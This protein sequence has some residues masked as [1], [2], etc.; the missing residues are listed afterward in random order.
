M[1]LTHASLESIPTSF[2]TVSV[3][4]KDDHTLPRKL[5]TIAAAGF[6]GIEL[7][8]PDLLS[9]ASMHLRHEVGPY[10]Y[11]DL[12]S[13]AK[14]V[15]AQTDAKN[16]KVM[17]LQPFANF[18]G[19]PQG[20]E[21]RKDAFKRAEGWVR[22]MEAVGCDTLQ[23]GST[24]TPAEKLAEGGKNRDAFVK[25][26]QE[27]ADMLAKHNFRMAYENW[28]WSTHAPTWADV[29][30]I[31]KKV[32]RPNVGLCL[33]TFQT[34]GYEWADPTTE[35]G[36]LDKPMEQLMEEFD[37]SMDS[38][39]KTIPADKI[40]LLQ[41]S[42]AY[43]PKTPF[44]KGVDE[45]GTRPRGR[46]SH[47]LRPLPFQGYLPVVEVAKAVLK[48]GFRGWFS[49]EVFDG[50]PDGKGKDYEMDDFLATAMDTQ[51]KLMHACAED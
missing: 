34:A 3:G 49:Y 16:L 42:D 11:D 46:W 19:W 51:K 18:E 48:T 33:D 39:A 24:D 37:Q 10:D 22:I 32:D 43:K 14:V 45:S 31:V 2:A 27:L 1:A 17:L 47:D 38:L 35:S 5:D 21:E 9:F 20:S 23:V 40:Y 28:C 30:D 36:L 6:T 7:G 44:D 26:L 25:D 29:W 50:G 41:I 15:K 13:A 4:C 8:F 12:Y